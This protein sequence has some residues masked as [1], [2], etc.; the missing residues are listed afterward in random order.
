MVSVPRKAQDPTL[1]FM[2][3]IRKAK[4]PDHALA[5]FGEVRRQIPRTKLLV[6]GDGYLRQDLENRWGNG[7]GV[8]FFGHVS[9][10]KKVELLS[11]AHVALIPG[12]REGWGQVV[13]EANA[14]GTPAVGY[15][16]P[17]IRD[18]IRDGE[19]G[20]LT[21]EN[22]PTGLSEQVMRLFRDDEFRT[23]LSINALAWANEFSWDDSARKFLG[24]VERIGQ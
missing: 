13:I 9:E 7:N 8:R 5:A 18:S 20:L 17:G 1:V 11:Q 10:A 14:C 2:G 21:H 15:N 6:L 22:T 24:I 4:L 19:T 3:R 23:K 16:I 12:V